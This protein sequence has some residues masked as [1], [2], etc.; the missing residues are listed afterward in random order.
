MEPNDLRSW[1]LRLTLTIALIPTVAFILHDLVF[2][3]P[4]NAH[5]ATVGLFLT[6]AG[7]LCVWGYC[8]YIIACR[9]NG[10][11]TALLAG[12][13]AGII[14]VGVLWLTSIVLNN[15]FPDRMIYEPDGIRAFEQSGYISMREYL[16]HGRGWGPAPL[17]M[18]VAAVVGAIG[19]A[20]RSMTQ[21]RRTTWR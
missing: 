19:G 18:F 13:V 20:I 6:F 1:N 9:A 16:N 4:D 2:Q 15:V 8:G 21:R 3:L 5:E 14:S 11:R 10:A 7:L 12:A 17:L